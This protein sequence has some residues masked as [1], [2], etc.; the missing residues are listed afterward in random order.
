MSE[1]FVEHVAAMAGDGALPRAN[2]EFVFDAPWQG[3]QEAA[4][5][6]AVEA[7]NKSRPVSESRDSQEQHA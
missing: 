3:R 2:G 4:A 1:T 7:E 6:K 5:G